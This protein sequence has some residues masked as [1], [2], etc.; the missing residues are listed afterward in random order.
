[1]S[2]TTF[3]GGRNCRE[4]FEDRLSET[5]F[6]GPAK[7]LYDVLRQARIDRKRNGAQDLNDVLG[8]TAL[9][10]SDRRSRGE[11]FYILAS[12]TNVRGN[13]CRCRE[14]LDALMGEANN[15]GRI[16]GKR[17]DVTLCKPNVTHRGP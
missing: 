11:D 2:D 9:G 10:K 14:D 8:E 6:G 13:R 17:L 15:G 5:A 4:H 7:K 1:M 16:L 12:E 3:G